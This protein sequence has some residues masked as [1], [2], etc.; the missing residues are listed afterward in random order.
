MRTAT[1]PRPSKARGQSWDGR[2]PPSSSASCLYRCST[3]YMLNDSIVIS[4]IHHTLLHLL[5]SAASLYDDLYS[6]PLL[7]SASSSFSLFLLRK[8]Y[9]VLFVFLIFPPSSFSPLL[10][11][12]H[13]L[14][15]HDRAYTAAGGKGVYRRHLLF[16][17]V[18][19]SGFFFF[20]PLINLVVFHG[21]W[22]Q[23]GG[24]QHPYLSNS[25]R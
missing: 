14:F 2:P 13:V 5:L 16:L 3:S 24:K 1:R 9:S 21:E 6:F 25:I 22:I 15:V 8:A 7:P 4:L 10:S 12:Y 19:A 17:F 20:E 18:L 23:K 11:F